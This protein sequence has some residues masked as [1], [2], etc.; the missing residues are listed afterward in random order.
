MKSD[1]SQNTSTCVIKSINTNFLGKQ[2]N[3]IQYGGK[4]NMS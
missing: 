2:K 1:C 3:F 4:K